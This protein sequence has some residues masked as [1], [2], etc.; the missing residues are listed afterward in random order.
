M[1]E[2]RFRQRMEAV[3]RW[4]DAH[5][6][7]PNP[8]CPTCSGI[9][10]EFRIVPPGPYVPRVCLSC[11]HTQLIDAKLMGVDPEPE[12]AERGRAATRGE[13]TRFEAVL[14]AYLEAVDAGWA[15]TRSQL[16]ACYTELAPQLQ[17]FFANTDRCLES[18][19]SASG[20]PRPVGLRRRRGS[21]GWAAWARGWG[22]GAR[23]TDGV[24]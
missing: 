10:W 6:V 9:K 4:A 14:A 19:R 12:P 3:F 11:G 18:L 8:P 16:L 17:A 5:H 20:V 21:G 15:P 24:G 13:N 1:N 2:E 7:D 23:A 22:R